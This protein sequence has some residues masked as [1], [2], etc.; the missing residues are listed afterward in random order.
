M[1][2]FGLL[3][4]QPPVIAPTGKGL[5]PAPTG[6]VSG[7]PAGLLQLSGLEDLALLTEA[8]AWSPEF[9]AMLQQLLPP[10]TPLPAAGMRLPDAGAPL[11]G[12]APPAD[13]AAGPEQALLARL[14]AG[15]T[16][17]DLPQ[18]LPTG[19][20]EAAAPAPPKLLLGAL[21]SQGA[22][23]LLPAATSVEGGAGLAAALAGPGAN[24]VAPAGAGAVASAPAAM[25][26]LPQRVGEPGW[27]QALGERVLWLAG[28]EQQ[29][30]ELRLNPPHLGPLE[31]RV[32]VQQDQASLAFLSQ[33]AAV[34]EALE[35][36]IPRLRE[37]LGQQDLQLVQVDVGERQAPQHQAHGDRAGSGS[38]RGA[39][40]GAADPGLGSVAAEAA[41]VRPGQGL[42][43]LFA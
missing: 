9:L 10:G 4:G 32:V 36:A 18:L 23:Q 41:G 1:H 26:A 25:L 37:L 33:H 31:V 28:R 29:V 40:P 8:G 15:A 2:F 22:G 34:R 11:P 24:A 17:A 38:G 7:L 42:V 43:D 5:A 27:Q 21:L 3:P 35:Q 6:E 20:G 12:V 30:A 16:P 14:Q 19:A 39:E 13:G